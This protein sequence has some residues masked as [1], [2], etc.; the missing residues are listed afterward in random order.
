MPAIRLFGNSL[1]SFASKLSSGYWDIF[2]PNNGFTA[3]HAAVIR[4]IPMEKLSH[5][6]FFESDILF[7]LGIV[8][9][10]VRDVPMP[11]RYGDESSSLVVRRVI[12]EFAL[13]HLVNTAKR[14]IYNYYLR[15]FNMASIEIA[16]GLVF[17]FAGTWFGAARWAAGSQAGVPSTSGTV[18]LAAL[19]VIVGVQ[20]VLA[21]LN[22]DLQNIPTH[23]LHKRFPTRP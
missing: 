15:N 21:F 2:D 8:R 13:K 12:G 4:Q 5:G 17:V 19:P 3:I 22:Y 14:I 10:V 7:R 9:A 6:W 1:L 11:A 18:M 23:V 20:F 16:L